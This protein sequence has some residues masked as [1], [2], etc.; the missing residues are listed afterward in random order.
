MTPLRL[1]LALTGLCVLIVSPAPAQQKVQPLSVNK[2]SSG[3]AIDAEVNPVAGSDLAR[4][5]QLSA[6]R[7]L[8]R[9]ADALQAED[10]D[11]IR[12]LLAEADLRVL[13]I[14]PGAESLGSD[15]PGDVYSREQ[16]F[17]MLEDFFDENDFLLL[18]AQCRCPEG[19]DGVDD[20]HG[21]LS[22]SLS[23]DTSSAP[24]DLRLFLGMRP[25][26]GQWQVVE[27][28]VLP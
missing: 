3:S 21:V 11:G 5:A 17:Y 7:L 16:A 14:P 15:S 27:I 12:P 23:G 10:A 26:S 18:E 22:L 1:W 8:E 2:V 24:Q 28:R 20:A 19:A 6:E 9:F 4:L 25:M 13:L